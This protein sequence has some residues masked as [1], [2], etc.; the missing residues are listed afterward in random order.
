MASGKKGPILSGISIRIAELLSRTL[1]PDEQ[2]AALGDLA[3]SELSDWRVLR[4]ITGLV[5]RRQFENW[6]HRRPWVFLFGLILPLGLF[7][8]AV[9]R[10]TEQGTAVY[11]WL[12]ANNSNWDLLHNRG[13]WYELG[14][15]AFLVSAV[16]L[17]L[18]CWSWAAGFVV[19]ALTRK[20]KGTSYVSICLSLLIG[21]FGASAYL[22]IYWNHFFRGAPT[23][24]SQGD[25]VS[26]ILFYRV[27]LPVIFQVF[28]VAVPAVLAMRRAEE[29]PASLRK[30]MTFASI[31]VVGDL[32]V[33][34][35]NL[36]LGWWGT[37]VM[38]LA[39]WL[40]QPVAMSFLVVFDLLAYW[41]VV[42]LLLASAGASRRK[43][44]A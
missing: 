44:A 21:L 23:L 5:A 11:L 35:S 40:H 22:S 36:W 32:V 1:H 37:G 41:P 3:E 10:L 17:K 19:A 28:I 15:T 25:P 2:E 9:S 42:Y 26:E 4:E 14:N 18:A 13:F 31:F 33:K 6:V 24:P 8:S 29:T 30:M 39:R 34:N 16:C 27:M 12:Y 7:L 43:A 20:L 38:L